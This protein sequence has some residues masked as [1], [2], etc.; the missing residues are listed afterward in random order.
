MLFSAVPGSVIITTFPSEEPNGVIITC[1][2][3]YKGADSSEPFAILNT[4]NLDTSFSTES[5]LE[6][7]SE[8]IFSVIAYT[9]MGPGNAA[10][11]TVSTL[12]LLSKRILN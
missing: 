11:V 5:N 8:Y 3:S 10:S 9:Q 7:G 12:S 2:M 1:E 6:C 4:A